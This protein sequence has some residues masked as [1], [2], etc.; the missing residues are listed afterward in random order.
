MGD[1]ILCSEDDL[2]TRAASLWAATAPGSVLWLEGELGAGKTTFARMVSSAAGAEPA[3]SPTFALIHEYPTA[4]GPLIHVD[5]YRLR[6][7]DEA[8][9]LDFPDLARRARALLIEWPTR[10]GRHAPRP[11]VIVRLAHGAD[12]RY[13]TLTV[14]AP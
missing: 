7:P 8:I 10:A 4:A 13:R 1:A 2:R 12:P 3:T 6:E 9:A 11:D 14:I 5:C